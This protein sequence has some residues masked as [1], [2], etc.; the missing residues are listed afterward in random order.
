MLQHRFTK[1][2]II[3]GIVSFAQGLIISPEVNFTLILGFNNGLLFLLRVWF[4]KT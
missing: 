4:N 1:I 2:Q 3:S